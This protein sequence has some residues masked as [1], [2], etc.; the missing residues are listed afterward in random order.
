PTHPRRPR[1]PARSAPDDR[2]GRLQR[3]RRDPDDRHRDPREAAV[4]DEPLMLHVEAFWVSPWGATPY[5]ALVE[6]GL[7]FTTA[8]ALLADGQPLHREYQENS[9][10]ARVPALQH[11]G[12]WVSESSAI[13][14]Y[15]E[16][17]FP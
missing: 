7:P 2:R 8:M 9:I 4:N 6:K 5:V 1:R 12:F 14:E 15:L 13:A 3:P 10:T 16:E 11:G 17:R